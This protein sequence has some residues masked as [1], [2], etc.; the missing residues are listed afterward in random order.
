[1]E[2]LIFHACVS[3]QVDDGSF[4]TARAVTTVSPR[5]IPAVDV[6]DIRSTLDRALADPTVLHDWQI[7]LD[8]RRPE[9]TARDREY[10]DRLD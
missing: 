2:Y 9:A 10:A 8:G 7:T 4:S 1:V 5:A 6:V 3:E